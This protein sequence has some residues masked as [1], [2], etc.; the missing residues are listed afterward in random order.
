MKIF[1]KR[2]I[3]RGKGVDAKGARAA[4]RVVEA[5]YRAAGREQGV[6][7]CARGFTRRGVSIGR[8]WN[9]WDWGDVFEG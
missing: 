8:C 3:E 4:G 7:N 2:P 1:L 6:M 9:Q 5:R